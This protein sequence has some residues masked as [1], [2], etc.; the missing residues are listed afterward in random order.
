MLIDSHVHIGTNEHINVSAEQ[1]LKSMDNAKIDK[2]LV[3]A[4]KMNGASNELML[5]SI[6]P[7]RD[8]L[9]GVAA[10]HPMDIDPDTS[11]LIAMSKICEESKRIVDWHGEGKIVGCKF[12]L[13]YD[14]YYP[15]DRI[16]E[17]YLMSL[18]DVGCTALFHCGDCLCSMKN[19]KLKYS[20]PLLIDDIAVDYPKLK[21]VICHMANPFIREAAEVCYKNDNVFADTSGFVYGDFTD[22]DR[23]YL[24]KV[25][26][27]YID[28]AGNTDKLLFGT[29]FPISNQKDYYNAVVEATGSHSLNE[30]IFKAFNLK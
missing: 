2:A 7:Y 20:H 4:G 1:L 9:Y 3:F 10:A 26:T 22:K 15:T 24:K 29:D 28:I 18:E 6:A 12:Y 21:I 30:N 27:E 13:G 5:K 14:H 17:D 25:M 23:L 8:R 16:V 19:A 11:S